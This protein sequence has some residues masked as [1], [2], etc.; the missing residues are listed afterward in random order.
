VLVDRA[1]LS[2]ASACR[3]L[4]DDRSLAQTWPTPP[5]NERGYTWSI[6][7]A[8]LRRLYADLAAVARQLFVTIVRT[9]DGRR[10][11]DS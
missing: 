3:R 10:D 11:R 1:A 8:R 6:T 4:L 5:P 9:F 2:F 7:A